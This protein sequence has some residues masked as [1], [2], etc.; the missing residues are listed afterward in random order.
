MPP[1]STA[2]ILSS[3]LASSSTSTIDEDGEIIQGQ[4]L[5]RT[6]KAT[7]KS[8][9]YRAGGLEIIF[10][11]PAGP[12]AAR[13]SRKVA[14]SVEWLTAE[15]VEKLHE[16]QKESIVDAESLEDE[17]TLKANLDCYYIAGRGSVL[18]IRLS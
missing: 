8:S 12:G 14:Y 10:K 9:L 11:Y 6:I 15:E 4:T 18:K 17:M 5:C 1:E 3:P 7:R 2:S 13:R 16:S